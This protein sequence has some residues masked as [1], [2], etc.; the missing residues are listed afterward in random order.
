MSD[1]K[2]VAERNIRFREQTRF[3]IKELFTTSNLKLGAFWCVHG[4]H[5]TIPILELQA[6]KLNNRFLLVCPYCDTALAKSTAYFARHIKAMI[7]HVL[8]VIYKDLY[9]G[10]SIHIDH[11]GYAPPQ[12]PNISML[13]P[14]CNKN[15][16]TAD[17]FM[18][19]LQA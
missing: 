18:K 6:V 2:Q 4:C 8:E 14:Y 9:N 12:Q 11:I 5:R 13:C 15:F 1:T 7:L 10:K 19:H 17:E 16:Q 3:Y